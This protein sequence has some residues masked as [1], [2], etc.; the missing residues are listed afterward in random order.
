MRKFIVSIEEGKEVEVSLEATSKEE[1]LQGLDELIELSRTVSERLRSV[2]PVKKAVR[3]GKSEAV[4]VLKIL[5]EKI[6]PSSFFG[7]PRSTADVRNK[8]ADETGI[9]F[10][11]RKVSQALGILYQKKTLLRLGPKG[12]YRWVLPRTA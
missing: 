6:I 2:A 4:E 1:V 10:Q 11:S 7:T 5:E 12:N 8:I 9:K 3:R